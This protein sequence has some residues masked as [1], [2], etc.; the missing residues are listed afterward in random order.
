MRR[1][2]ALEGYPEPKQPRVVGPNLRAIRHRIIATYRDKEFYDGDRNCGYGGYAYD[3][4]WLPIA[5][6]MCREYGLGDGAAVL[7]VACEKGFLLHDF[8]QL[9]PT[10]K[11]RGTD[12]S[13]YAIANAMTSVKPFIQ[14]APFTS[15]PF[16]DKEFD[17]VVA[18][19]V[20]YFLNLTDAIQSLKEIQRVGKGKSFV[21]LAS[22][23]TEEDFRLFSYW[24]L[25]G[26]TI[27]R[28]EEWVGV[29]DHV[30]YTGDYTFTNAQTLKLAPLT[31][32]A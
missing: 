11:V 4:R 25:L 18:I 16:Q 24:T 23:I 7:Q 30:G 5:R 13:D 3:G 29:L 28:P 14:K 8:L 9:Q 27:L 20:V 26:T 19:G 2:N 10:M 31:K 17:F 15:L 21:T 6:N 32:G 22:Y 1:F 12:L